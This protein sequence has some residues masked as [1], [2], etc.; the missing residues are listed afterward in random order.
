MTHLLYLHGFASSANGRKPDY[1]RSQLAGQPGV[2]FHALD[3][4]PTPAD[5]A[6]LTVTG[7][8]NRL[9]QYILDR[10]LTTFALIGSSMGGL[11]ALN[12]AARFPGAA[13]LLLLS[14]ALTYLT[15]ERVGL[16]LAEWQAKGVGEV[17]HYGFNRP[18]SLRYDLEIDGRF[19]HT[20]PPPPA[21]ITILHGTQ[22]E[23][24]P[25]TASRE[26]AARYPEQVRL[27]EVEAE[28]DINDHLPLIWQV[29][30]RFLLLSGS[31]SRHP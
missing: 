27:I 11:V 20:P 24:V 10:D 21:P 14:P 2:T 25:V 9:R 7:M 18:V 8:M 29:T 12:Y 15:G 30:Q 4:S 19:Y 16:P 5:F 26:Y 31:A 17:F 28:H 3:F 6:Y 13:R 22:D 23:V 1:L